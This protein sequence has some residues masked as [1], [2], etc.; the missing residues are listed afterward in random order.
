[1][2]AVEHRPAGAGIA[3]AHIREPW[4]G[5]GN[6][7][8]DM[9][10]Q[11]QIARPGH[12]PTAPENALEAPQGLSDEVEHKKIPKGA[13]QGKFEGSASILYAPATSWKTS[14]RGVILDF[15]WQGQ[16]R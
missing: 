14:S 4:S 10:M 13:L 2:S 9:Q 15:Y 16:D 6:V 1:M 3:T 11:E 7:G 5:R 12:R 8:R